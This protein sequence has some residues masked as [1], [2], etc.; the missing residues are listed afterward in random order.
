MA[1]K[2]RPQF[3][4]DDDLLSEQVSLDTAKVVTRIAV[5]WLSNPRNHIPAETV[6][7]LLRRIHEGLASL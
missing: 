3:R 7:A 2:K 1:E 4:E 6:P 5:A